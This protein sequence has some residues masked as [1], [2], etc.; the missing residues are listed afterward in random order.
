[1]YL[2]PQIHSTV[3]PADL[4]PRIESP[5]NTAARIDAVVANDDMYELSE[6]R[7]SVQAVENA[8]KLVI[9]AE[10]A[11]SGLPRPDI[12]VYFGEIDVTWKLQDRLLRMI[13]FS[14][15][16][17]PAVLYLQTDKGEA[18]TRGETIEIRGAKDL[19]EKLAWLRGR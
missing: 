9:S 6:P 4:R 18:L 5:A 11:I 15:S 1:M 17:R 12:S 19:S 2:P 10:E 7:P 16:A 8:K 14:D 13:V 3:S